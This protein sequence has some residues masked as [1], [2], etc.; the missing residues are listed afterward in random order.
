MHDNFT[1]FP[2]ADAVAGI[3]FG[4]K[5]T[6]KQVFDVLSCKLNL[7]FLFEGSILPGQLFHLGDVFVI[8]TTNIFKT[9]FDSSESKE[10]G[11][12]KVGNAT[13]LEIFFDLING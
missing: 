9:L 12:E 5:H 7:D 3:E 4:G 8:L 13:Q 1:D 2:V 10:K 6:T 11:K